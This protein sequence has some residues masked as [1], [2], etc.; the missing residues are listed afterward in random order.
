MT[1]DQFTMDAYEETT[2]ADATQAEPDH[3]PA[4]VIVR[5]PTGFARVV[6]VPKPICPDHGK[7]DCLTYAAMDD[8]GGSLY[9]CIK[10]ASP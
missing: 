4:E 5:A 1:G 6:R 9:V 2:T 8:D 3:A 7:G 10:G